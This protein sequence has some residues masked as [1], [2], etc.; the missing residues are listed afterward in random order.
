MPVASTLFVTACHLM[1]SRCSSWN[2]KL[3]ASDEL[4]GIVPTIS[5]IRFASSFVRS[6]RRLLIF[7]TDQCAMCR[8]T[9]KFK[10][11]SLC[12]STFASIRICFKTFHTR[13]EDPRRPVPLFQRS[14]TLSS[15]SS[16]NK[17]FIRYAWFIS[18]LFS[19]RLNVLITYGS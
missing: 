11:T 8:S 19:D 9:Q 1:K 2:S 16:R 13:A 5:R 17:D 14:L 7:S 4:F 6:L 15:R 18:S 12:E 3:L 10:T